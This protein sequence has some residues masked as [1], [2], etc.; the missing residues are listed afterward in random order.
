MCF[1]PFFLSCFMPTMKIG[2]DGCKVTLCCFISLIVDRVF[3]CLTDQTLVRCGVQPFLMALTHFLVNAK[4]TNL[5]SQRQ[6]NSDSS[7]PT[8][9]IAR[10]LRVRCFGG[11]GHDGLDLHGFSSLSLRRTVRRRCV[12]DQMDVLRCRPGHTRLHQ[13]GALQLLAGTYCHLF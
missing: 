12:Q 4:N 3:F 1:K 13:A 8:A 11:P 9:Q 5:K 7:F 6:G 2:M 10:L